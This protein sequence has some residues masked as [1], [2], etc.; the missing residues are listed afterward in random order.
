MGG[1]INYK[2]EVI[3]LSQDYQELKQL[4]K[5]WEMGYSHTLLMGLER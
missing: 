4:T 1:H 3:F 5:V 2:I